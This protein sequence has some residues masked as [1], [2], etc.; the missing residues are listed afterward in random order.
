[1][2]ATLTQQK[3]LDLLFLVTSGHEIE[4]LGGR[5]FIESTA[6]KPEQVRLW[7]HIGANVACDALDLTGGAPRAVGKPTQRRGLLATAAL[8]PSI[9]EQFAGQA[10]Y[11]TPVDVDSPTAVGEVVVFRNA[12]YRPLIGLVGAA[13]LHHTPLDK[14]ALATSPQLLEPVARSL[15]ATL[16][17]VLAS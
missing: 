2:A 1:M 12:G 14:A 9:R 17:S 10:G 6:P 7:L 11:A 15:A 16:L 5:H 8:Q 3:D 13:P 4:G